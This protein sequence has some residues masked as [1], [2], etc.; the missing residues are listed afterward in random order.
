MNYSPE[1]PKWESRD[2]LV[3]SKGHS[4]C[5][6]YAALQ[7][8]NF[9]PQSWENSLNKLGTRLPSH[10]D[11]TKTPGID[12]T[13][14]SLGQGLS[15]AA[16]IAYANKLKNNLV[17][18]YCILGDGECQEGQVWEALMFTG[19]KQIPR[20]IAFI[21]MN[22]KQVDGRVKEILAVDTIPKHAKLFGWYVREVDGHDV[23]A[24]VESIDDAKSQEKPAL[25][26]MHTIKGKD[27][28]FAEKLENNHGISVTFEQY[29]EAHQYLDNIIENLKMK[30]ES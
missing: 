11:R 29:E 23:A 7:L 30:E 9:F 19:N 25:I 12:M 8:K 22:E 20:L 18:T 3:M 26:T 10:C 2:R 4:G 27:C 1:D 21:D 17:F 28:C 14:G 15:V 16:G 5:A 24:L 13:T 6:I